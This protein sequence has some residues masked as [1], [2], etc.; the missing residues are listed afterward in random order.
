[1]KHLLALTVRAAILTGAAT[2][3]MA[4]AN[5]ARVPVIDPG[6]RDKAEQ[7]RAIQTLAADPDVQA[8]ARLT[9]RTPE[10]QAATEM[11]FKTEPVPTTGGKSYP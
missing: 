10:Q 8:R 5:I 2:S 7:M 9:G 4:Q 1:M 3:A 11:F 6:Q